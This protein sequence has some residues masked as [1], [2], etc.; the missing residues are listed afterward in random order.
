MSNHLP[1]CL[2]YCDCGQP[3]CEI[4]CICDELRSCEQRVMQDA[5]EWEAN[6]YIIGLRV[7]TNKALDAAEKA[8]SEITDRWDHWEGER[9]MSGSLDGQFIDRDE[10]LS[11]IRGLREEK[12]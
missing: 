7:G 12:Q 5:K 3:V 1:E 9:G 2:V 4:E 8:V 11:A 6:A 10:A